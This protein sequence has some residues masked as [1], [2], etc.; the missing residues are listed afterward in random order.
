[1]H[2]SLLL[3]IPFLG[4]IL[5]A[6]FVF[7]LKKD[8][9]KLISNL[10]IGFSSGIMIASSIWSLMI[11]SIDISSS[12]GNLK[13][14]P[15]V[16]GFILGFIFMM[17]MD[18]FVPQEK[19]SSNRMVLAITLHNI[20]EGMAVGVILS[21]VISNKIEITFAG[22]LGL[23]L[24]IAIQNVPEGAI[25]SLPLKAK[26]MKDTKAFKYG[27]FS[28][29]VEPLSGLI[30]LLLTNMLTSVLPYILSFGGGTMIYVVINELIPELKENKHSLIGLIGFGIGFSL[31]MGLDVLLG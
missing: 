3:L 19:D 20:P 10:L 29:I 12:L 18:V 4:T 22:A 24:G 16:C 23:I 6:L 21:G 27:F 31:M 11:P 26:G 30:T 14:L 9:N 5:G 2:I 1:M 17:C 8:I 15:P 13:I 25:V 28:G 7:L